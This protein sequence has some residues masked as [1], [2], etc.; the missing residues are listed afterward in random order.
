MAESTDILAGRIP[1]F[2]AYTKKQLRFLL[3]DPQ[4][5]PDAPAC[6]PIS[7]QRLRAQVL[8]IP[9]IFKKLKMNIHDYD[10]AKML[11]ATQCEIIFRELL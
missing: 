5:N 8:A 10:R 9:G 7:S 2:R 1:A 4:T 3:V 11:S 6:K